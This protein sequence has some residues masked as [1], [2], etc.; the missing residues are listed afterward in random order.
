MA[1]KS[2]SL[3]AATSNGYT[4][5]ETDVNIKDKLS[6]TPLYYAAKAANFELC[7]FLTDL[8]A[9]VNEFCEQWEHSDAYGI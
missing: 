2:N 5:S 7:L 1:A 9:H 4:Y 3:Y 8:H 6:N